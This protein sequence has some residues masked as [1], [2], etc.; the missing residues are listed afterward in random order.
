MTDKESPPGNDGRS[1]EEKT[2]DGLKLILDYLREQFE[3]QLLSM[4]GVDSRVASRLGVLGIYLAFMIPAVTGF[5][6]WYPP[7]E[8]KLLFGVLIGLFSVFL[9][10]FFIS[11]YLVIKQLLVKVYRPPVPHDVIVKLAKAGESWRCR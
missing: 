7:K 4:K 1:P 11:L 10:F 9:A 8:G 6:H 5:V 3:L 2:R